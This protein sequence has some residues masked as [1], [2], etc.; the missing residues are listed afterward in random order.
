MFTFRTNCPVCFTEVTDWDNRC[1]K[2]RYHPDS[3]NRA[4]DDVALVARYGCP[5]HC[6]Q[7]TSPSDGRTWRRFL[8]TWLGGATG[9]SA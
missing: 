2:C 9:A 5:P 6:D 7:T 3:Y 4:Q 8:P 1:P